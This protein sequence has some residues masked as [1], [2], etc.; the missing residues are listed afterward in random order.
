MDHWE[1][2]IL[3]M[4]DEGEGLPMK[5]HVLDLLELLSQHNIAVPPFDKLPFDP[6]TIASEKFSEVT[7]E[8]LQKLVKMEKE[9]RLQVIIETMFREVLEREQI[10]GV[11]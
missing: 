3:Q 1:N 5:H 9:Y 2:V 10:V 11:L 6:I 7:V 4:P 8:G